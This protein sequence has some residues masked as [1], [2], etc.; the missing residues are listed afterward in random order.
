M[1]ATLI[2]QCSSVTHARCSAE[3][4]T[5]LSK[6]LGTMPYSI[7]KNGVEGE[8]ID[9]IERLRDDT[10]HCLRCCLYLCNEILGRVLID[11]SKP[12]EAFVDKDPWSHY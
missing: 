5:V 2:M 10:R 7:R 8:L 9:H 3:L 12:F 11:F 1:S 4:C 6:L